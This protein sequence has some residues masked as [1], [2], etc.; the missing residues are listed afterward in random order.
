L[1]VVIPAG[2]HGTR[3]WPKSRPDRPKFLIDVG[4]GEPLL[5]DALRRALAVA[6]ADDIHVVTGWQHARL[7]TELIG[8]FGLR[9]PVTEPFARNTTAALGLA[10]F[11][12]V[13]ADDQA[14]IVSLPADHL[15]HADGDQWPQTVAS[16]VAE[17]AAGRLACVG[18][19]PAYAHTGYGY[20]QVVL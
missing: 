12:E 20:V 17:T 1:H 5:C 18:V 14:V 9:P 16:L 19:R 8:A 3:L 2:G 7:T 4:T 11:I 6:E 10:T 15:V 13:A